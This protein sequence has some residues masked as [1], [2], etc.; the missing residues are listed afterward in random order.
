MDLILL[1]GNSPHNKAWIEEVERHLRDL[2]T[3]T[4]IQY[5]KHWKTG[6]S[7]ADTDY[8]ISVLS[9]KARPL[10]DFVILA[11][12]IGTFITL[13][14]IKINKIK[15]KKCILIGFPYKLFVE[16]KS[17]SKIEESFRALKI[18]VLFIQNS[19]DPYGSYKELVDFLK[20]SIL[21]NYKTIEFSDKDTHDYE[22]YNKL[23]SLV[24]EF[25][26]S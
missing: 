17:L 26:A 7:I 24:K 25:L 12:S 19:L 8:E 6:E 15:P 9:E 5:Y 11:K 4:D 21:K 18:P 3:K 16:K 13:E 10:K 22:D 2:F 1:P 20:K 14:S 23:K